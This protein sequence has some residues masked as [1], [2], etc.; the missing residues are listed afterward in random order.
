M[1]YVKSGG[2]FFCVC[3]CV[4]VCFVLF[5]FIHSLFISIKV[6]KAN[7]SEALAALAGTHFYVHVVINLIVQ[8]KRSVEMRHVK[9]SVLLATASK[10]Q[11]WIKPAKTTVT[12]PS[13]PKASREDENIANIDGNRYT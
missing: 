7:M 9:S 1:R 10:K 5:C 4:C 8:D 6:Y 13:L 3:V 12:N 11:K 2:V